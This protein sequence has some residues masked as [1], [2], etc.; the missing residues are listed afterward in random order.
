MATDKNDIMEYEYAL[1]K[2]N[3][4]L[5]EVKNKIDLLNIIKRNQELFELEEIERKDKLFKKLFV[6]LTVKQ[7]KL[8][9]SYYS[10]ILPLREDIILYLVDNYSENQI[11]DIIIKLERKEKL[12]YTLLANLSN[13]QLKLL[14]DFT[15]PKLNLVNCEFEYIYAQTK[16]ISYLCE[17]YSENEI[18]SL[19][20]NLEEKEE[21][22]NK[23]YNFLN[24]DLLGL[25][26]EEFSHVK[27]SKEVMVKY[28]YDHYSTDEIRNIVNRLQREKE[29]NRNV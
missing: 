26:Y 22:E 25:L 2:L 7:I 20:K 14:F 16:V 18:Y 12:S 23:I 5:T 8:L 9:Y 21:I 15:R 13:H 11:N 24:D 3:E 29:I 4:V 17:N 19:L 6:T 1:L 10:N 28:L 27:P